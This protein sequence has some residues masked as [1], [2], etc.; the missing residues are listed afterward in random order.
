MRYFSSCRVLTPH[1]EVLCNIYKKKN[2]RTRYSERCVLS[3]NT[4]ILTFIDVDAN[5]HVMMYVSNKLIIGQGND[6]IIQNHISCHI[7]CQS[8]VLRMELFLGVKQV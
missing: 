2:V 4:F 6:F 5:K 3:K 1:T 8:D 7:H